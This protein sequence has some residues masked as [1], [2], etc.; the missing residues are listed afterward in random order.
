MKK[1]CG[2]CKNGKS[3]QV[4]TCDDCR[5]ARQNKR[6]CKRCGGTGKIT[7]LVPCFACRLLNK[8]KRNV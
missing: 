2:W 4:V 6:F 8:E 5:H 1:T 3:A 7:I